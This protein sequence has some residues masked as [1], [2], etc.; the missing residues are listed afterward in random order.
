MTTTTPLPESS[1]IPDVARRHRMSVRKI[2]NEVQSGRLRSVLIGGSRRI[3]R[4]QEDE[5]LAMASQD[6]FTPG[7]RGRKS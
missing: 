7:P 5:W 1:T 3:T 2:Y 6:S 4:E